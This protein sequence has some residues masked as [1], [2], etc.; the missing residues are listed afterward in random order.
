MHKAT[1]AINEI[2][3]SFIKRSILWVLR[4][5]TRSDQTFALSAVERGN[6]VTRDNLIFLLNIKF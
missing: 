2:T 4:S 3:N 6:D 1:I 5:G